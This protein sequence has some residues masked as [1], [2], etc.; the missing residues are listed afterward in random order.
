MSS[1]IQY[2][3]M[4]PVLPFDITSVIID[5]VGEN[6]DKDL[7]KVLAL[8]SHSFH[9]ISITHLFADVELHD[10]VPNYHFVSSKTGFVKLVKSRPHLVKYIRKLTYEAGHNMDDHLLA[11]ILFSHFLPTISHLN[12]LAINATNFH[13]DQL[14]SSLTSAFLHLMSLPTMNYIDLSNIGKFPL[15]SLTSSVNL[16]RLDIFRLTPFEYFD[17]EE[18]NF[19]KTVQSEMMPKIRELHT[20]DACLLTKKLLDVKGRGGRPIFNLMDLRQ[21]SISFFYYEDKRNIQCLLENAKLLERLHVSVKFGQSLVGVLST[22][23]CTLKVLDLTVP[24]YRYRLPSLAGLCEELEAMAGRNTLEALSFEVLVD[25]HHDEVHH[26]ED[27]IGSKIQQVENVLVKPG[28]SALRQVSFKLPV[29]DRGGCAELTEALQSL[30]DTYL[31]H[32]SKLE[33]VAFNYSAYLV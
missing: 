30:P 23:A 29:K 8:V 18:D 6:K 13:W 7:L 17:H 9:Q 5:I 2:A 27:S 3:T 16:L 10:A 31:R 28:W 22:R 21:L 20:W 4:S 15:S 25:S 19:F 12:C 33:S 14:D 24:I 26:T 1:N 32:L 11:P